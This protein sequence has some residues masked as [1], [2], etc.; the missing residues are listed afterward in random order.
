MSI[1]LQV[2]R[3]SDVGEVVGVSVHGH[4]LPVHGGHHHGV[5]AQIGSDV[6]ERGVWELLHRSDDIVDGLQLPG[7]LPLDGSRHVD[8]GGDGLDTDLDSD[9]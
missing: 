8:I 1:S 2:Q 9:I 7:S 5:H 6:K 4:H 3:P